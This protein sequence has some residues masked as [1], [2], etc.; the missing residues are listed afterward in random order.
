LW[1]NSIELWLANTGR[2]RI[3]RGIYT[4]STDL[5]RKL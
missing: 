5:R 2:D 4:S 3:A 1:L